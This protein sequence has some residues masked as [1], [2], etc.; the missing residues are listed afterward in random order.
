MQGITYLSWVSKDSLNSYGNLLFIRPPRKDLYAYIISGTPEQQFRKK[1][2]YAL[3][4]P[5]TGTVREYPGVICTV[6]T[7]GSVWY[8]ISNAWYVDLTLNAASTP[9]GFYNMYPSC[10]SWEPCP[11]PNGFYVACPPKGF[12]LS[13]VLED[14]YE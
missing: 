5:V 9:Q 12:V 1:Y 8:N 13:T 4:Y 2:S 3:E 6:N 14:Y 7:A 11:L 10:T